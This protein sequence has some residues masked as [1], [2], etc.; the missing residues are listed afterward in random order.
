QIF[1]IYYNYIIDT[2]MHPLSKDDNGNSKQQSPA[3]NSQAEQIEDGINKLPA[4][5]SKVI[6]SKISKFASGFKIPDNKKQKI[7]KSKVHE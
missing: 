5:K 3:D 6:A 1:I 2:I 4:N 7:S